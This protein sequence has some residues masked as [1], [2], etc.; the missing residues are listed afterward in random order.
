MSIRVIFQ[1][2]SHLGGV[3][4]GV[5]LKKMRIFV[6][7]KPKSK[8]EYIKRAQD[9]SFIVAVKEP[10]EKGRANEAV[11]KSLSKFLNIPVSSINFVSGQTSRQ[12]IFEAPMTSQ[13]LD[14]IPQDEKGQIKLL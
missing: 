2:V 11:L 12:K 7:A 3:M 5:M 10:P 8:K 13:D 6:K 4:L 1:P 9:G 14:K